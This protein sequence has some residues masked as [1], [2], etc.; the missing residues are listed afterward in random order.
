MYKKFPLLLTLMSII[1]K[2]RS[3]IKGEFWD[4]GENF[5]AGEVR[6]L[7]SRLR[8]ND[9]WWGKPH[10]TILSPG[11]PGPLRSFNPC[12]SGEDRN[13]KSPE[14]P[15]PDRKASKHTPGTS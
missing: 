7:D 6:H 15:T 9:N 10:P 1:C 8:G 11:A 4:L 13:K 3:D 14:P 12:S 2:L 5:L